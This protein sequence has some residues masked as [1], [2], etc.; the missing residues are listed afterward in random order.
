MTKPN[1][2]PICKKG[3]S[4]PDGMVVEVEYWADLPVHFDG[5]PE[6]RE[7]IGGHHFHDD[8]FAKHVRNDDVKV[9]RR[10]PLKQ[11]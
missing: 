2:C 11:Y 6:P 8:C 9:I 10:A 1:Y 7:K 5:R 3:F 4:D